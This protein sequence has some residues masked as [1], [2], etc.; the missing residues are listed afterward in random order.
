MH[1]TDDYDIDID[2]DD[3]DGGR[4]LFHGKSV[5]HLSVDSKQWRKIVGENVAYLSQANKLE[6]K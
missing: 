3:N 2:G 5:C 1:N 6:K 4:W